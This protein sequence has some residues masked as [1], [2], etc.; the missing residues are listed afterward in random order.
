MTTVDRVTGEMSAAPSEFD[1]LLERYE[2]RLTSRLTRRELAV[3]AA[4]AVLF[5]AVSAVLIAAVDSERAWS[6]GPVVAVV[7]LFAGVARVQ[8]QAGA[9]YTR[10]TELALVPM[11]FVAPL[12]AVPLLMVA[13]NVL[14][15]VP[16]YVTGRRHPEKLVL[17][18]TDAWYGVGPVV[19]LAVAGAQTPDWADWPIYVAALAGQLAVDFVIATTR[20][21]LA[22][23]ASPAAIAHALGWVWLIDAL[24]APIGLLAAFAS[25]TWQYAFLLVAPLPVALAIF[26][27]ERRRR[28]AN[29]I[30]L[31]A[32]HAEIERREARR[33]DA[34]EINDNVVQHLAVASYMLKGDE[35]AEARELVERSLVE[36][37]RI[38]ADLLEESTPGELRRRAAASD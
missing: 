10:P 36:A 29:A 4:L 1:D 2:P 12:E 16:E 18:I 21:W 11:L 20:E 6:W 30:E 13:A 35:A 26:A 38:I 24:L 9:G 14:S 3:E 17:D 15:H 27:S 19:V 31:R 23:G 8:F 7:V 22:I 33:R 34:L 32:A 28:I 37:K 25:E 5:V